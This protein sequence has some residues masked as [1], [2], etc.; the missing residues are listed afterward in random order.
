MFN[1]FE[2]FDYYRIDRKDFE[3]LL[4]ATR[5]LYSEKNPYHNFRHAFDVTHM[6]YLLLTKANALMYLSL[7]E[8]LA[9]MLSGLLHDVDHPGLNNTFQILTSSELAI[10][11]N[12]QSVLEN[13]HSATAFRL[14][15]RYNITSNLSKDDKTRLRKLMIDMILATDLAKHIKS[16]SEF[17]TFLESNLTLDRD[18]EEHRLVISRML[19]KCADLCNPAKPFRIA[20]YWAEMIQEEFFMQGEQEFAIGLPRSPFM[21]RGDSSLPQMQVNFATY[22]VIPLYQAMG[23]ILPEIEKSIL[24]VLLDNR[25]QWKGLLEAELSFKSCD[26]KTLNE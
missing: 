24:P 17:Q 5:K 19:L 3:R 25:E 15:N 14:L 18:K 21:E 4:V 12:D 1:H 11:Y 6:V 13:H 8:V 20:K 10:I 23:K 9:L 2:L 7:L 16:V 26:K 22:I